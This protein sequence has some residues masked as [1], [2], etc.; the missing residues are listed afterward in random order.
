MV[1]KVTLSINPTTKKRF[2][3]SKACRSGKLHKVIHS[4]EELNLLLDEGEA[5]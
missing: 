1:K 2:D 3:S 5:K 4:D